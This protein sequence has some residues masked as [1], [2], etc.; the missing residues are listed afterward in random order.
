MAVTRWASTV[1]RSPASTPVRWPGESPG[2]HAPGSLAG[3]AWTVAGR[4]P[5]CR[6]RPAHGRMREPGAQPL[7]RTGRPAASGW[8]R[9]GAQPPRRP[10]PRPA[11]RTPGAGPAGGQ[12]TVI[13]LPPP[14]GQLHP[15]PHAAQHAHAGIPRGDD[16]S[17]G[18]RGHRPRQPGRA[19]VLPA[20]G[21]HPGQGHRRPVGR[22]ALPAVRGLP[23]RR[24]RRAPFPRPR[25][26]ARHPDPGHRARG[27][28]GLDQPRGLLQRGGLL[29]RGRRAAGVPA[30]R[31]A[32]LDRD[33]VPHLLA[34]PLVRGALRCGPAGRSVGVVDAP[35]TGPG[36]P[37]PGGGC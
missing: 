29:A 27:R 7:G 35:A 33:R 3:Q 32:A 2:W 13:A 20:G 12:P 22:L 28:G 1:T 37:G 30:P 15:D 24:G 21:L 5:R 11:S 17:V 23:A 16:G 34:R 19:G 18:R 25:R 26:P 10:R 14:P 6:D 4:D 8:L 36:V 9:P 31:P